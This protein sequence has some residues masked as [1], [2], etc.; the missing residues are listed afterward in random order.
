MNNQVY[1]VSF[2]SS[3]MDLR[4]NPI[5][6]IA[7]PLLL[8]IM[9]VLGGCIPDPLD[10]DNVP[11]L[12][13]KI[14]IGSQIIPG[15][16]LLVH[17][18]R[19]ISA[20]EAGWGSEL[21]PLLQQIAIDDALVTLS[22]DGDVDTLVHQAYGVYVGASDAVV[23][24]TTYTLDVNSPKWGKVRATTTAPRQVFFQSVGASLY[25]TGYDSLARIGT[26]FLIQTNQIGT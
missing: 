17:V 26:A 20:L 11:T 6:R 14:V 10:V 1:S 15:Q 18:T 25:L 21:E 3:A 23:A 16:G 22:Y 24:G 2:P 19:S 12:Q 13:P 9:S 5:S 7:L 4:S 8:C